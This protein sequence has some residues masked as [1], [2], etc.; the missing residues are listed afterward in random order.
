MIPLGLTERGSFFVGQNQSGRGVWLC[1]QP[2]CVKKATVEPKKLFSRHHASTIE[3]NE[4]LPVLQNHLKEA[5]SQQLIMAMRCGA[6][7]MGSHRVKNSETENIG[8]LLFSWDAGTQ[9]ISETLEAHRGAKSLTIGLS[10]NDLGYLLRR[11]PRSVLALRHSRRTQSL[12]DTLRAWD[13][14]G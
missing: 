5:A 9:T 14:L 7:I 12:I 10:S 6:I 4:L 8:L 3:P 1:K 13:S 11:G 2:V